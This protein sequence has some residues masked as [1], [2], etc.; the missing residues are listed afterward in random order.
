MDKVNIEEL[1]DAL[2]LMGWDPEFYDMGE[3][4]QTLSAYEI[5]VEGRILYLELLEVEYNQT[6][7]QVR[8]CEFDENEVDILETW[9]MDSELNIEEIIKEIEEYIQMN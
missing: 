2:A 6:V 8:I 5:N 3:K 9:T 4:F 1:E 7:S